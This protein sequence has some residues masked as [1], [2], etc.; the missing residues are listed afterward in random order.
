MRKKITFEKILNK[1]KNQTVL[2]FEKK[3]GGGPQNGSYKKAKTTIPVF[4][5]L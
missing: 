4:R 2:T 3:K 5:L 1:F